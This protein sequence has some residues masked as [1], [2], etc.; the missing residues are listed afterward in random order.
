MCTKSEIEAL[1]SK[2]HT[3]AFLV[4]SLGS[5]DI[6]PYSWMFFEN[7]LLDVLDLY[8][9]LYSAP[10]GMFRTMDAD[11]SLFPRNAIANIDI[12]NLPIS[13]AR[14]VMKTPNLHCSAAP[15]IFS[16]SVFVVTHNLGKFLSQRGEF[17]SMVNQAAMVRG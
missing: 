8:L 7:P 4:N 6:D 13:C 12:K 5:S 2:T 14:I 11:M 16:G 9:N 3:A 1:D 17:Q 10:M 15:Y